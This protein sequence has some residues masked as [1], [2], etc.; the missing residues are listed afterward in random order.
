MNKTIFGITIIIMLLLTMLSTT[1]FEIRPFT[2]TFDPSHELV[3]KGSPTYQ[4][5]V[6]DEVEVYEYMCYKVNSFNRNFEKQ[7]MSDCL[8]NEDSSVCKER[9][10]Q[11]D[12]WKARAKNPTIRSE[13]Q[14]IPAPG[15]NPTIIYYQS[16]M[17]RYTHTCDGVSKSYET[18]VLRDETFATMQE[19][20]ESYFRTCQS[21]PEEFTNIEVCYFHD[22]SPD[23]SVFYEVF[24]TQGVE[25][26]NQDED[27]TSSNTAFFKSLILK[28]VTWFK[29]LF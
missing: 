23:K 14:T 3:E 24:G 27:I 4:S 10:Y 26:E 6:Y 20:K 12:S 16:V 7:T 1:A 22:K 17:G 15:T 25:R 13:S 11:D 9:I 18:F 28:V 8:E 5:N 21:F 19:S 2:F 29:K